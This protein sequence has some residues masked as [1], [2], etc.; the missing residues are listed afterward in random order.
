M[1]YSN[2]LLVPGLVTN[3][4]GTKL[5]T[6]FRGKVTFEDKFRIATVA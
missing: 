2:S 3:L 4:I 6:R 5:V 1:T